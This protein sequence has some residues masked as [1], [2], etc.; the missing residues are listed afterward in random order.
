VEAWLPIMTR[1][2]QRV[3][4]VDAFAGPG[5]YSGGEPGSPLIM[6]EAY[7]RHHY[8]PQM[9]ANVVYLFIE[10]REDRVD[11]LREELSRL[12]IPANVDVEVEQGRYEAIFRSRLAEIQ[13]AGAQLAPTFAFVDPFGYTEA[14]MDLT[15]TFMQFQRCEALIYMPLPFVAR[16]VSREGQERALCAL[17]GTD[18]WREAIELDGPDRRSFLHDL[19]RD[20]MMW[21]GSRYVRSFEI[22][23]GHGNGYHLFFGTTHERG[24]EKMKEAMWSLDRLGGQS[25]SDSTDLDQL[26]LF[27]EEVDT[28]PLITAL[29]SRFGTGPFSIEEAERFTLLAT[30][31][32]PSAH[33]KRK[34]LVPAER[35]GLIEVLTHRARAGTFPTRTQLRFLR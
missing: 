16:F 20:Q 29:R 1:Y 8:Q 11:H 21:H 22:N 32:V 7:L 24:L 30:P 27:Q 33:L 34:T 13:A 2:N 9:T 10:E 23:A 6:L 17:F 26:V 28:G 31:Y 25:Y 3:V 5:R 35:R 15:G 19:F 12:T 14:P 18:R 4:L